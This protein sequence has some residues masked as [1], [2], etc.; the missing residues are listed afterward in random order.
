MREYSEAVDTCNKLWARFADVL[1]PAIEQLW[2]LSQWH[3][4]TMKA[5]RKQRRAKFFKTGKHNMKR[6][7]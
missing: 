1:A 3:K 4:R 5:D 6:P 2:H 7:K